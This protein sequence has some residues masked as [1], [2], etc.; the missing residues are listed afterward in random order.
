MREASSAEAAE[1]M[2][3]LAATGRP[4]P[5][6]QLALELRARG[7]SLERLLVEVLGPVQLQVGLLWQ[8]NLWTAAQEHAATAVIDGVLGALSLQAPPPVPPRGQVLVACVEE[9]YHTV[10]ARM[11]VERLREERWDVVFLGA[12][13][14]AHHLQSYAALTEPDVVVLSCTVPLFLPGAARCIAAVAD[15]G[16]PAVAAGRGF[17]TTAYR[18]H[19][20]GA[21][22]WIGGD[23]DLTD[24]LRGSTA[25][26]ERAPETHAVAV[27]LELVAQELISKC[28]DE[29]F[30]RMPMMSS[31]SS[32]Q[33]AHTR[34]DL[35][36]ILRYLGLAL[37]LDEIGLFDDFV[38]WLAEVLGCRRVPAAVL[39]AS[40]DILATVLVQ[41]DLE[42]P[43]E[44]CT[45]ARRRLLP[46]GASA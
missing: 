29:M 26:A 34:V 36:Y 41:A 15:L 40:L 23:A 27:Q 44:I 3:D 18:A 21:S 7:L 20:L 22:G 17:G 33:M 5:A 4:R 31:Y 8:T 12:S 24:V 46:F 28:L 14:P 11:G 6:I 10:P 43:A 38:I 13:L 42:P 30:V 2:L 16:L 39:G 37:D 25:P 9:E 19:R 35:G 45:S 1:Q 32:E